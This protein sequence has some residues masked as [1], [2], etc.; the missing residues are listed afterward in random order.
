MK[1]DLD[2]YYLSQAEPAKSCLLAL[3]Q[4]I[5]QQD[6]HITEAWKYRMPFFCY[7]NKMFCYLWIYKTTGQPYLG[8]V[9]GKKIRHPKLVVEKRSRMAV[10]YIDVEKD[11]PIKTI[12]ELIKT[13]IRL[14]NKS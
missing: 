1:S 5:L 3:R 8:I 7:K 9:D 13:C 6:E 12:K 4:I 14:R 2:N 11:L 10:L